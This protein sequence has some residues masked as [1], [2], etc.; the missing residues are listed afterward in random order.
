MVDVFHDNDNE[1]EMDDSS[2]YGVDALDVCDSD[3]SNYPRTNIDSITLII[4]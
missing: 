2:N 1:F 3:V 4:Y